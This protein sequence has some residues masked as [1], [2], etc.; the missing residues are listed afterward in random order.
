[1]NLRLQQLD[2]H[3]CHLL[4][5]VFFFFLQHP[6]YDFVKSERLKKACG[7]IIPSLSSTPAAST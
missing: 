4:H 7:V 6:H 2:F 5:K 1:M 3:S